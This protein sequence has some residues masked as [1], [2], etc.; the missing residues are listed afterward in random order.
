MDDTRL[1]QAQKL[2]EFDWRLDMQMANQAGKKSESMALLEL[3]TLGENGFRNTGFQ[4]GIQ[5]IGAF[6]QNL[7]KIKDQLN[8]LIG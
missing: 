3:K 2:I 5:Q 7:K 4:M 8:S 1:T 6:H